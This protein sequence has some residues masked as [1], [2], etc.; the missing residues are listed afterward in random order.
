MLPTAYTNGFF[1]P[2]KQKEMEL[3]NDRR[4]WNVYVKK[5]MTDEQIETLRKQIAAY[6]TICEQL[7]LMHK[8]LSPNQHLTGARLRGMCFDPMITKIGSRQRWSPTPMQL[9][10][11]ERIFKAETGTPSKEKI[12]EITT[13][14]TKHGQISETNVYNWFQ[15][16]R[17]RS[18]RKQQSST[19]TSVNTESEVPAEVDSKD[20]KTEPDDLVVSQPAENLCHKNSHVCAGSQYLTPESDDSLQSSKNFDHVPA[21]DGML[22]NSRSSDYLA[23]KLEAPENKNME[24]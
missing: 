10:T 17:A 20:E 24:G 22:S 8:N 23:E 19:P 4:H 14:L 12:K 11:L 21:I 15:N 9:Q 18:K 1:S 2:P 16:R 7:V 6:G 5:V 13:N 3:Q